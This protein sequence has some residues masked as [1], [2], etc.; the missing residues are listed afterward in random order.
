MVESN[1]VSPNKDFSVSLVTPWIKG[2]IFV[3]KNFLHVNIQNTVL[4]GLIPAGKQRDTS[5]LDNLSNVYTSSEYKIGRLF[6]GLL[7]ILGGL[8]TFGNSFLMALILILIGIG[9]GWSGILTVFSYERSGIEKKIYLPFFEA[10]HAQELEEEVIQALG[11]YQ[12]DRNTADHV[13]RGANQITDA[14]NRK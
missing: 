7:F 1:R 2:N 11:Q 9:I 10:S 4:F 5:P 12:D 8:F 6:L 13:T 14:I 3:D